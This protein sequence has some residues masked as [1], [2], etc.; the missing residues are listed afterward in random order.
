MKLVDASGDA[1]EAGMDLKYSYNTTS[2]TDATAG[3]DYTSTAAV[4]IVSRG[5]STSKF[6]IPILDDAI[7]EYDQVVKVSIAKIGYDGNGDDAASDAAA[8]DDE[9]ALSNDIAA[10]MVHTYTILDDDDPPIVSFYVE[11]GSD[12]ES[13]IERYYRRIIII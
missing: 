5:N 6:S 4:G 9:N 8:G 7:D 10:N 12:I 13:N 11:N 3:T 1:T 2:T